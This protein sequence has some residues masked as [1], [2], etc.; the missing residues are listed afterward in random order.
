M[1]KSPIKITNHQGFWTS[2]HLVMTN[3]AME[4]PLYM[5]VSSWETHL[6]MGHFPRLC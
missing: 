4:N 6:E 5:E 1:G 2:Y 3:I